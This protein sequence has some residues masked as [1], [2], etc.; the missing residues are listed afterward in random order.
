MPGHGFEFDCPGCT[1]RH[2]LTTGADNYGEGPFTYE[3]FV[4]RSCERLQSVAL[5]DDEAR[6]GECERCGASLEPWEGRVWFESR[7]P[8]AIESAERIEGQCPR[9]GATLDNREF[10]SYRN[11]VFTLWD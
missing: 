9:C 6:E 8:G 5:K 10:V 4:C 2:E 11:T 3:Q 7:A 1:A